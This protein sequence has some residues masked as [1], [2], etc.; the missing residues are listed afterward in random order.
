MKAKTLTA[1]QI[2]IEAVPWHRNNYRVRGTIVGLSCVQHLLWDECGSWERNPNFIKGLIALILQRKL[3]RHLNACAPFVAP[4][5]PDTR[6]T[7][8]ESERARLLQLVAERD[9]QLRAYSSNCN[10]QNSL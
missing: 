1:D 7:H 4:E 9:E 5:E 8:C 3:Q 2:K 10:A 6:L